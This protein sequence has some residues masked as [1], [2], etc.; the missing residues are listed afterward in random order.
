MKVYVV[1]AG[2]YS[3]YHIERVFLDK[4]K[5]ERYVELSQNSCD[6]PYIEEF[7]TDDDKQIDKITYIYATYSK[8]RSY[9]NDYM[10]VEIKT[11]NTL[12][13]SEED[14][15]GNNFWLYSY[16]GE[17]DLTVTRVLNGEYDEEK[18]KNKY[19]KVCYDLMSK[20]ESLLEIEGWDEKMIQEWLNQNVE[21][22][23]K[24]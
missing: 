1:T 12:D 19:T 14:V 13:S 4:E 7:E 9:G 2:S 3:D 11:T 5:A 8:D 10:R 6:E 23:I 20:I 24:N 15:N 17:K 16:F 22:Y 21:N 18:L